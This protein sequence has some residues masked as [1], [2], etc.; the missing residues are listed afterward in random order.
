MPTSE[1]NCWNDQC[2]CVLQPIGERGW[3]GHWFVTVQPLDKEK[4]SDLVGEI[5]RKFF[6]PDYEKKTSYLKMEQE[7]KERVEEYI[8]TNSVKLVQ[9]APAAPKPAKAPKKAKEEKPKEEKPKEEAPKENPAAVTPT[10]ESP[11]KKEEKVDYYLRYFIYR[12]KM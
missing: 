3:I 4:W 1:N 8:K 5:S 7:L 10:A 2:C 6:I 11:E 12:S 9:K